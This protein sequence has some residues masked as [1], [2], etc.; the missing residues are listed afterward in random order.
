M[1]AATR[2]YVENF[3]LREDID[4]PVNVVL[5]GYLFRGLTTGMFAG[6]VVAFLSGCICTA[7]HYCCFHPTQG[8]LSGIAIVQFFPII[9]PTASLPVNETSG[10]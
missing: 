7:I 10:M 1:G 5:D 6:T 2:D 8:G 3:K 4:V 9:R